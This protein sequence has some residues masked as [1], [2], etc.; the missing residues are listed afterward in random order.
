MKWNGE[1]STTPGGSAPVPHPIVSPD[2]LWVWTGDQWVANRM[3]PPTARAHATNPIPHDARLVCT[4]C[5]TAFKQPKKFVAGSFALEVLLW[6]LFLLP[7]LLYSIWRQTTR[8]KVCPSCK[9]PDI[10]RLDTPEGR[11]LQARQ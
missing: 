7:G 9:S 3:P 4:R 1:M 10:I 2:G 8:A 5:G 11:R 6:L